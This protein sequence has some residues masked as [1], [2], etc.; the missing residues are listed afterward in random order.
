MH[1]NVTRTL[2]LATCDQPNAFTRVTGESRLR[3][4]NRV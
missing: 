1:I 3:E 4:A 2:E